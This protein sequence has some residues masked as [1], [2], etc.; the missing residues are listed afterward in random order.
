[1]NNL[2]IIENGHTRD[3]FICDN[4]EFLTSRKASLGIHIAKKHKGIEQIDG[5]ISDNEDPY[6]KSYWEREFIGISYHCYSEALKN[7][8]TS[9][10]YLK[11]ER[12][13]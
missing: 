12:R 13:V 6:S 5:H 3:I 1:M 10:L 4:S 9:N 2:M 11:E 8:I 7:L